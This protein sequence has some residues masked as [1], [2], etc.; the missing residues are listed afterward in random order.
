MTSRLGTGKQLTFSYS[1][2]N[3]EGGVGV[4]PSLLCRITKCVQCACM[5]KG[6]LRT[7]LYRTV[8]PIG[9]YMGGEHCAIHSA[10]PPVEGGRCV[11]Y[12]AVPNIFRN[13][14]V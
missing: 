8:Y 4:S 2:W 7:L 10:I 1:V 11:P 5:V 9:L 14:W 3:V 13:S 6:V 12:S